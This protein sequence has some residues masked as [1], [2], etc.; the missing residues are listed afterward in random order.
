M[1]FSWTPKQE[2]LRKDVVQFARQSLSCDMIK[3]DREGVFNHDAWNKCGDFGVHGWLIPSAYGGSGLDILTTIYGMQAL[4][5]ACKDNG[6]LFGMNAH[7][8]AC[9][10][11]LL[12]FG[13]NEQKEKY[14]PLL[15]SGRWIG[16]HAAT[17][18][19]AG[20]DI[21]NLTTIAKKE[22]D[23]YIINGTKHYVT[24]GA[25]ADL[26]IVFASIDLALGEKGLTVF[27]IEKGTPGLEISP[28]IS[29]M[30][31]R[32]AQV[33]RLELKN[34]VVPARSRLGQEGAGMT[35]FTH[36]MEW[37]RGFILGTAVGTMQ[38]ILEQSIDYARK[39]KQF[40]QSIAKF[41]LVSTK[42]V[43][44]KLLLESAKMHLYKMAW[45]KEQRKIALLEAAITNLFISE[46]WVELCM[47]AIEIHGGNGYMTELE[48][49]RELRDAIGSKFY[50]GTSEIQRAV[51]AKFIGA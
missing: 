49:E 22:G 39:H 8:W 9:E 16:A 44:M 50:S 6:M 46:A 14:L 19:Q 4:G 25:V 10:M 12:S 11:P 28:V 37:E 36:S 26:F 42:L 15:A 38:R 40:G 17:E 32:T 7:I 27:L 45:M 47:K 5:Y 43:D 51:I 41:Q 29:T 31:D 30:G 48:L 35:I 23:E 34:C 20:S 13:N 18:P 3:H 1:D 33:T 24:N 21:F 2:Q